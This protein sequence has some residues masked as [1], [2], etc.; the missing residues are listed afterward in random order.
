M[1]NK[2]HTPQCFTYYTCS[3]MFEGVHLPGVKGGGAKKLGPCAPKASMVKCQLMPSI[4]HFRNSLVPLF[5]GESKCETILMKMT[6]ICMK[7]KLHAELIFVWKVSHLDSL[8]NRGTRELVN[9]LLCVIA[10][11]ARLSN[12]TGQASWN[13]CILIRTA[14]PNKLKKGWTSVSY[15]MHAVFIG[16]HTNIY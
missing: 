5:Q 16:F 10:Q 12:Y 8:W 3:L 11:P 13:V 1:A 6:L 2:N 4:N 14:A 9:G 15:R 7:M